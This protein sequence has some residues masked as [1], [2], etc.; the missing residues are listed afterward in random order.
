MPHV[1]FWRA[2]ARLAADLEFHSCTSILD[3]PS[4]DVDPKGMYGLLWGIVACCFVLLGSQQA[5]M[6]THKDPTK[7]GF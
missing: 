3:P 4:T 7:H 5:H 1:V 6:Y 2:F